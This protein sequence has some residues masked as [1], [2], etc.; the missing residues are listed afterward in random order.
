ML[1]ARIPQEAEY[2]WLEAAKTYEQM[3][4][5]ATQ[6]DSSVP[7]IWRRIGSAY[8]FASRQA[9]N[10]DEFKSIRRSSVDAFEKA[11]SLFGIN[12]SSQAQG[13]S[14]MCQ[15][16]AQYAQSWLATEP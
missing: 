3:L 7:E 4:T 13:K 12:Q 14:A 9:S 1:V 2:K 6:D 5:T 8:E 10:L 15:A 16:N 11:S